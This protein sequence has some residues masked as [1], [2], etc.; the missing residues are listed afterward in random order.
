MG[1]FQRALKEPITTA[2]YGTSITVEEELNDGTNGPA[3]L[4]TAPSLIL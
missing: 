1:C 2:T 4:A 3:I